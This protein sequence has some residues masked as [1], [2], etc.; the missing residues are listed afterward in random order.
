MRQTVIRVMA[1]VGVWLMPGGWSTAAETM[2]EREAFQ[3]D[4]RGRRDPFVPLV[5]GGRLV[6]AAAGS[7]G[8]TTTPVLYGI[9]WDPSGQSIALINDGEYKVGDTVNSYRIK[10]IRQDVVVLDN[11]G[12]EP[13]V[14]QIAFEAPASTPKSSPDST[15]GGQRR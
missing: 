15:K 7:R 9:M 11:G 10:D 4:A 2:K 13:L 8:D 12:E 6:A 1:A 5:V 3:Y 14:L